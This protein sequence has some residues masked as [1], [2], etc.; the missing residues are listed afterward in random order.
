M[1]YRLCYQIMDSLDQKICIAVISLFASLMAGS[2]PIIL[3]WQ[4]GRIADRKK[5]DRLRAVLSF[6]TCFSAGVFLGTCL[7]ELFPIVQI[8]ILDAFS[9]Y[10]IKTDFPFPQFVTAVGF[11][12]VITIETFFFSFHRAFESRA[13]LS[14]DGGSYGSTGTNQFL[15]PQGTGRIDA[16][17]SPRPSRISLVLS[18]K[19]GEKP[20][21]ACILFIALSLHT[22][23]EGLTAGLEPSETIWP[24]AIAL[25]IHKPLIAIGINISCLRTT[26]GSLRSMVVV[27][28]IF[29]LL[30]S[31]GMAIGIVGY[32]TG[33]FEIDSLQL[34]TGL[35]QGLASGAF[36]YV[37]FLETIPYEM[38]SHA[39]AYR[40]LSNLVALALGFCLTAGMVA[41]HHSN[42]KLCSD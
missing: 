34:V 40:K 22:F 3:T 37:V 39:E 29:A 15:E 12:I 27:N 4:M 25:C 41:A 1:F 35:F 21:R 7:L 26:W 11:F 36:L 16:S 31:I 38:S 8:S 18:E 30:S 2:L 23:F 5:Y 28:I 19:V 33:E 17:I 14:R 9:R 24:H 20:F 10:R 42:K 13:K 6:L 32:T